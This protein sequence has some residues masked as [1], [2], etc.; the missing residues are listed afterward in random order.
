MLIE[1]L[2]WFG[3]VGTLVAYVLAANGRLASE[4]MKYAALNAV[5]GALCAVAAGVHGAWPSAASSAV[6]SAVGL[7][8]LT[9]TAAAR[10]RPRGR[11]ITARF[12]RRDD[13][14]RLQQTSLAS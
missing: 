1:L 4:S 14:G 3:V 9:G 10:I 13:G 8:A 6:W 5:G 7:Y 12:G 2:G 11:V